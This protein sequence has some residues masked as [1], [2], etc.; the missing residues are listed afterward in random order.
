MLKQ[1]LHNTAIFYFILSLMCVLH[2]ES[3]YCYVL[4]VHVFTASLNDVN[5]KQSSTTVK[6]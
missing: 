4:Y 3:H 1:A 6:N 2:K 5:M